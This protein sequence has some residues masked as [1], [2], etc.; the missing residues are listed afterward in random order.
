MSYFKTKPTMSYHTHR[1]VLMSRLDKFAV[2]L[3]S[4]KRQITGV[5]D[6]SWQCEFIST[7]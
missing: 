6:S 4:V 3:N 5:Y 2:E 7:C 1:L